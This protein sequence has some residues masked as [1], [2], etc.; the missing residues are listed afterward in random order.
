MISFI[1]ASTSY[2]IV[3]KLMIYDNGILRKQEDLPRKNQLFPTSFIVVL[4]SCVHVSYAPR[5]FRP[6][7]KR[8]TSTAREPFAPQLNL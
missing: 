2:H 6:S 3:L 4:T 7:Q 8:P 5:L 1:Q